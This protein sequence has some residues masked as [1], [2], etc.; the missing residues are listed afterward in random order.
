MCYLAL[1][2]G[3]PLLIAIFL[4]VASSALLGVIMQ[5]WV[6]SPL[7]NRKAGANILLL[8][9][10][11]FYVIIEN[12][13][14]LVFGYGPKNLREGPV[15]EGIAILGARL[16]TAQIVLVI[17]AV[18]VFVIVWS[19]LRF[20]RV[21]LKLRAVANDPGLAKSS[22]IRSEYI[23]LGAMLV[24]SALAGLFGILFAFDLDLSPGIGL[25]PLMMGIVVV[26]ISGVDRL[27]GVVFGS[28]FLGIIQ[29]FGGWAASSQ[30]QDAA[31]FIVLLGFLIFR[32]QGILGRK[33]LRMSIG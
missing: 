32:P 26:V 28:L 1:S 9:S 31:V 16:T 6:F 10:L 14:G 17:S 27:S 22:G 12:L 29:N 13:L 5:Y 33:S 15:R 8:A 7:T 3:I 30:W 20:S 2:V 18:I 21:G 11:G 24:G 25:H 4:A 23:T 19:C